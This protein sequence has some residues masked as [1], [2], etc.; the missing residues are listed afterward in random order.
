MHRL[1]ARVQ[2]MQGRNNLRKINDQVLHLI[3]SC[4]VHL[5]LLQE[6]NLVLLSIEKSKT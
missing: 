5:V 3:L 4:Q 1:I 6:F 2:E